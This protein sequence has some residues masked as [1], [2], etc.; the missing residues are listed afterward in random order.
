MNSEEISEALFNLNRIESACWVKRC[1]SLRFIR[2]EGMLE[3]SLPS[4]CGPNSFC[5]GGSSLITQLGFV[6]YAE[7]RTHP[8]KLLACRLDC[9][10]IHDQYR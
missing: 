3:S 7:G 5:L 10:G 1:A 4:P 9:T 2:T 6:G 8:K